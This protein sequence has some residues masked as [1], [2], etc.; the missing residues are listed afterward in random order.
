MNAFDEIRKQ[1]HIMQQTLAERMGKRREVVACLLTGDDPNPTLE[2]IV[3]LLFALNVTADITLR[4]SEEGEG[5]V[6]INMEQITAT[7]KPHHATPK[8]ENKLRE[9]LPVE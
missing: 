7:T 9:S 8:K 6:R 4:P 1:Q 3:E 5:P 2:T